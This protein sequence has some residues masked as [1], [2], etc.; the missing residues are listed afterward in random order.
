MKDYN[1][2][3]QASQAYI[4][5]KELYM[6]LKE[7]SKKQDAEYVELINEFLTTNLKTNKKHK[8]DQAV[9]Q[10]DKFVIQ[11]KYST[12][13]KEMK[14]KGED[15]EEVNKVR[16]QRDEE[17]APLYKAYLESSIQDLE[18]N[19]KKDSDEGKAYFNKKTALKKTND[20]IKTIDGFYDDVYQMAKKIVPAEALNKKRIKK[21]VQTKTEAK[22]QTKNQAK[23]E[24]KEVAPM[25]TA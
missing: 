19:I 18:S 10:A 8:Q 23:K 16:K 1:P 9:Y 24:E 5:M 7:E 6:N 11:K 3:K 21:P 20:K 15:K 17:L 25:P 14:V 13:M 22:T 4:A 12:I 2:K